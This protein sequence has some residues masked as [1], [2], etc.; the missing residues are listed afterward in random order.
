MPQLPGGTIVLFSGK[1]I[2]SGW[3]LCDGRNGTPDLTNRFIL[4]GQLA[5]AGGKGGGSVTGD[6]DSR[7]CKRTTSQNPVDMTAR[8]DDHTLN[9]AQMPTHNHAQGDM[10]DGDY[11]FLYGNH[12]NDK[13]GKWINGGSFSDE[14]DIRFGPETNNVGGGQPHSHN[15]TVTNTEHD[16]NVNIIPPYYILAFI[17]YQGDE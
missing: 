8:A 9:V 15:V 17:M 13:R 7:T 14:K 16:H 2:P 3:L 11:D 1:T 5:D 10:Y 4:G 6:R 12:K